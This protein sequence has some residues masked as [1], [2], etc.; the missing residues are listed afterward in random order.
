VMLTLGTAA[1]RMSEPASRYRLVDDIIERFKEATELEERLLF[2][3]TL[4]NTGSSRIVPLIDAVMDDDDHLIRAFAVSA[5]RLVAGAQAEGLILTALRG[6]VHPEVR[7]SALM[8]ARYREP[9]AYLDALSYVLQ[10]DSSAAVRHAALQLL[11]DW[12]YTGLP[13]SELV[14]WVAD[15]DSDTE[16]RKLAQRILVSVNLR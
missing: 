3:A 7:R 13:V 11:H 1:N 6:D 4:G 15:H 2:L 9:A 14:R 12:Q 16:I 5:L 8:A 10:Q